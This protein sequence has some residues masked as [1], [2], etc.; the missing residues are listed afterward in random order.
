MASG[1]KRRSG[2]N[3]ATMWS[4]S[5]AA[6]IARRRRADAAPIGPA[7]PTPQNSVCPELVEGPSFLLPPQ[8]RE[9]QDRKTVAS[10]K[11]ASVRVDLGGRRTIKQHTTKA[12]KKQ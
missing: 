4:R 3:P 9:G 11:S 5:S 12:P 10:G 6:K 8:T 1:R 2:C 7:T